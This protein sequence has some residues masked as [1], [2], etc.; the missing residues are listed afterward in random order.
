MTNQPETSAP[1][2]SKVNRETAKI[3]WK[4]LQVH[5]ASG[6]TVFVDGSLDLVE[7]A[8]AMSEDSKSILEEM[9]A[10]GKVGH[11]TDTQAEAWLKQDAL[12]WAVV[13]RPWVLV[14]PIENE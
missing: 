5:F 13:I 8:V 14:Q 11:V 2:Y 12:L 3:A 9:M 7:V 1:L 10:Q 4:E 6:N